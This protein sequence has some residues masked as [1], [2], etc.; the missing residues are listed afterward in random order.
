MHNQL[1]H[2]NNQKK[3][4][5]KIMFALIQNYKKLMDFYQSQ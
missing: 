1:N 2:N 4:M 5:I 3:F